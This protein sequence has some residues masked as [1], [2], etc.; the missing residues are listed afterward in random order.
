MISKKLS[1]KVLILSGGQITTAFHYHNYLVPVSKRSGACE[2]SFPR[3][4]PRAG[5]RVVDLVQGDK[6]LALRVLTQASPRATLPLPRSQYRSPYKLSTDKPPACG[7]R[8]ERAS[9]KG[10]KGETEEKA[11]QGLLVEERERG[12]DESSERRRTTRAWQNN[13]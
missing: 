9:G 4:N 13:K 6:K 10:V 3:T 5:S 8:R 11:N 1:S 12:V 7:E 2:A